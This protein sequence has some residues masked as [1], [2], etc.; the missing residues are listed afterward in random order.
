MQYFFHVFGCV[1]IDGGVIHLHAFKGFRVR[2][3]G[4]IIFPALHISQILGAGIL[5]LQVG[6]RIVDV[7]FVNDIVCG[8][9]FN[10]LGL[11]GFQI[12]EGGNQVF[13]QGRIVKDLG[14]LLIGGGV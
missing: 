8:T 6:Y 1:L 2:R 3:H 14:A 10:G 13:A 7:I 5:I 11:S 9:G 4:G 12:F